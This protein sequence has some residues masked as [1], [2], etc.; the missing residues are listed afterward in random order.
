MAPRML[1]F[2]TGNANKLSEVKAILGDAVTLTSKSVDL[3][4]V[5]GSIEE[6]SKTKCRTAA[7]AVSPRVEQRNLGLILTTYRSKDQY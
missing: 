7:T 3:P 4:E 1:N 6:I 2:I 5:Q